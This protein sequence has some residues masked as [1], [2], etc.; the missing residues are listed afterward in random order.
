MLSERDTIGAVKKQLREKEI[1]NQARLH[2]I[3]S[4]TKFIF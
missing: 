2:K 4:Q 3:L 1:I